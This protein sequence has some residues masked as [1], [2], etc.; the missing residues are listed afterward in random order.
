MTIGP[1]LYSCKEYLGSRIPQGRIDRPSS[2]PQT[3]ILTFEIQGIEILFKTK[4]IKKY[5]HLVT[6]QG[7][8]LMDRCSTFEP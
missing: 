8:R 2:V 5:R 7:P 3:D 1:F 4:R 6:L